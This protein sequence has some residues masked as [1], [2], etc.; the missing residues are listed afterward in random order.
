MDNRAATEWLE[1]RELLSAV[2]DHAPGFIIAIDERGYLRYINRVLPQLD[3]KEVLGSHWLK[4]TPPE[5]HDSLRT[6]FRAVLDTGVSKTYETNSAGPKGEK[7]W[8]STYMGP[9]KT[10]GRIVGVVLVAQDI[11]ELR[12]TQLDV[13][14]A[15]R[16]AAVG[17]LAAGIAHEVNTPIQFVGDSLQFLREG[18]QDILTVVDKL[19]NVFRLVTL[20]SPPVELGEAL[21]AVLEA[22]AAADLPFLRENVS[23]AFDRCVDGL[24][25]V[26][27]IIKSIGEFAHPGHSEM[28]PVD[29]NRA[30]TNTL[31]IARNEYVHVAVLEIDLCTLPPI[32]CHVDQINQVVLNLIINAAHAIGDVFASSGAKGHLLVRT[33]MDG[34]DVVIC[35]SDTGAGIPEAIREHIFEPFFTTK[36]VG[37]GTGQG[38]ALAWSLVTEKHGGK[39]SYETI[40]GKGTTFFV[41]LPSA[42]KAQPVRV[43]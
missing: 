1:S 23:D 40:L 38:L 15:H 29:L 26:S 42:G 17:T 22:E 16:M 20:E 3:K 2:L 34:E 35:V 37:K 28:A 24:E 21:A 11:T 7:L 5:Q 41:R 43:N 8:F 18:V 39:L 19:Q 30:I 13:T 32:T 33:R 36:D 14:A 4:Y 9:M 12:R 25:R 31:N 27:T 10:G 6:W